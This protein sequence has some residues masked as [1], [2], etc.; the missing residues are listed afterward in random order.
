MKE[1]TRCREE[2]EYDIAMKLRVIWPGK[3]RKDYYK[4]AIADYASRIAKLADFEIIETR[5]NR[6]ED[7]DAAAR[8]RQESQALKHK[9]RAPVAVV[10]D[11]AGKMLTSEEFAVWLERQSSDVDFLLGGPQGFEIENANLRWS[12]GKVTLPHE[13]AR[14]VLL[15]QIYR[16]LT[17]MKRIPY[18]K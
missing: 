13:L 11:S 5:E 6:F 4:L 10:L 15:E 1:T 9:R 12:L 2:I 17:I 16:A 8:V 3:T 7:R 18:H 14:V